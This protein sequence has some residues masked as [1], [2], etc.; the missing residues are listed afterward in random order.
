MP[1]R[2]METTREMLPGEGQADGALLDEVVAEITELHLQAGL[3]Y[4][5]A[6]G[7]LL[8]ARF[9]GGDPAQYQV[10]GKKHVTY[11]ALATRE[12]LP[13][14][15][16]TLFNAVAVTRQ[17]RALPEE[18]ASRLAMVHHRALLPLK[19]DEVRAKLAAE[20]VEKGLTGDKLRKEVA[21]A[22]Q[23]GKDSER[24]GRP[25]LPGVVKTVNMFERVLGNT[26]AFAGV[27]EIKE[28]DADKQQEVAKTLT[29]LIKRCL[30]IRRE[31]D[32]DAGE[33][34]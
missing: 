34:G 16:S 25:P 3:A 13:V 30:E 31:I 21:R 9:F 5:L 14:S 4:H 18:H 15:A 11:R 24:R 6:L 23:A 22:L 8:L 2:T 7:H 12:D 27:E 32:P 17:Y 29:K 10:R 20:A 33:S 1:G 26:D 28:M 19:S